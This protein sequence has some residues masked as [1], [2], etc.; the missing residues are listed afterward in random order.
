MKSCLVDLKTTRAAKIRHLC[1]HLFNICKQ[2]TVS[3][4]ER[5]N[6]L[7]HR[8]MNVILSEF[9]HITSPSNELQLM[10][11]FYNMSPKHEC[12]RFSQVCDHAAV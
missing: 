11:L 5:D 1:I 3:N 2:I 7:I 12:L 9:S 8:R 10:P 6:H 4:L